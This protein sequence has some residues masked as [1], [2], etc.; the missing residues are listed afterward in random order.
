MNRTWLKEDMELVQKYFPGAKAVSART[1]F[2]LS[3]GKQNLPRL[4][5]TGFRDNGGPT[6]ITRGLLWMN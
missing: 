3:P 4:E 1:P 2:D 5:P 6:G